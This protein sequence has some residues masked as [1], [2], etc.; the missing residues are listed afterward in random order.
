MPL[1]LT[2]LNEVYKRYNHN[3]KY[4]FIINLKLGSQ[5]LDLNLTPN[6]R[7]V[8]VRRNIL[9]GIVAELKKDIVGKIGEE[10]PNLSK[11]Q[12]KEGGKARSQEAGHRRTVFLPEGP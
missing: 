2:N 7:E 5:H 1:I 3:T 11:F 10:V 4:A 9:E 6:K 8:F 12:E